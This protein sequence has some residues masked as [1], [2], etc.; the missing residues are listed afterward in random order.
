VG[1]VDWACS[2]SGAAVAS[3]AAETN[4]QRNR[5]IEPRISRIKPGES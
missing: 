4:A 1:S 2:V 5:F 3:T